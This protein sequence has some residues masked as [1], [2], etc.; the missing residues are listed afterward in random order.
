MKDNEL[1]AVI[2]ALALIFMLILFGFL[3]NENYKYKTKKLEIEC[4]QESK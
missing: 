4:N 1:I 2:S 3:I